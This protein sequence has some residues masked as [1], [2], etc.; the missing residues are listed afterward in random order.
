MRE[1]HAK[2][3][4]RILSMQQLIRTKQ[5]SSYTKRKKAS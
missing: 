3:R 5:K 4:L 2:A 1:M